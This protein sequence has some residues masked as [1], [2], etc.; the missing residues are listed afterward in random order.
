[1][2]IEERDIS[3]VGDEIENRLL[4][5][6]NESVTTPGDVEKAARWVE[7]YL[8][9]QRAWYTDPCTHSDETQ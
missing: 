7:V 2:A 4:D 6:I 3:T 8:N 5:R 1:M 9:F